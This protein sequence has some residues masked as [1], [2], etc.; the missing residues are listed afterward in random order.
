M[1]FA[2]PGAQ[3]MVPSTGKPKHCLR[4]A[5]QTIRIMKLTALLLTIFFLH[6]KA[7]GLSQTITYSGQNV[8]LQKVLTAIKDQTGYIFFYTE[9]IWTIS[10]PVSINVTNSKLKD[11]LDLVFRNQPLS[12]FIEEKTIIISRKLIAEDSKALT[13]TNAK[14]LGDLKG[15]VMTREGEPLVSANVVNK[16]TG[17]GTTTDGNGYF[18]LRGVEI[19]DVIIV[20][21]T[22]FTPRSVKVSELTALSFI[23]EVASS[24]LDQVV[25]QA[26]GTTTKRLATGNIAKVTAEEI[27][28]QPVLNPLQTLQGRVPG[29]IIT[30]TSGF[31]SAP[32][33]VEIRGRNNINDRITADPLYIIDGVPLTVM[34]LGGNSSYA[35]GSSGFI[36]NGKGNSSPARGQSPFFSLNPAD[37]ESIEI[38]KDAD[39]TAIYG[40]RGANGVILV[41]TK[42]G[43]SGKPKFSASISHGI[44]EVTRRWDMLNTQQ[45]RELRREALKNDGITPTNSN[46]Y[47]ILL[48]DSTR[49]TDWQEYAWGQVGR[50]T[51]AQLSL[52]GGNDQLTFRLGMG[53]NRNTQITTVSGA[54]QR[55]SVS[56]GFSFRTRDGKFN[57]SMNNTYSFAKSDMV[58]LPSSNAVLLPPNAPTVMDSL[59]NLNYAGWKPKIYPF[60]SLF[61]PYSANTNFLNS[62][63]SLGYRIV[64]GLSFNTSLGYNSTVAKN[65][66]FIPIF[67]QDPTRS[68][69]GTSNFGNNDIKNW[70]IEPQLEYN[71]FIAKGRLN[72]IVGSSI[73]SNSTTG[74]AVEGSGYTSDLLLRT[75]SNAPVKNAEELFGEYKY[76]AAFGRITYNWANK[77]IV[78][79]S[80]RRDGS[81]RFGESKRFGNFA[82]VGA[83]WVFSEEPIIKR[84]LGFLSFGKLRGSYG[85]TGSDAVGDYQYL[86]RW[87][88]SGTYPYAGVVPIVPLQHA[89]ENYHWPVN[90]KL[91]AAIDLGFLN[92]RINLSVAWYRNRCNDQ[93][94]SFPLAGMTGFT[95][96]TANSPALVQNM[97]LELSGSFRP[98]S[99]KDFKWNVHFNI[100]FNRNKLIAYPDIEKSPYATT[101]VVGQSLNIVKLLHYT[102]VDPQTGLYTFEDKFKDGSINVTGDFMDDRYVVENF[103]KFSGGFGTD[104]TYKGVNLS[105]FFN[106][107]KQRGYN[108]LFTN[109]ALPGTINNTSKYVFDRRWQKPGDQTEFAKATSRSSVTYSNFVTSDGAFTDASFIRLANVALSYVVPEKF[110]KKIRIPSIQLRLAA[111]NLF[112]ITRYKG[113]D[114]ETQNFGGMPPVK[115]VT[116]GLTLNF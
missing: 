22:G 91:E 58:S 79:I 26:Y 70:I 115:I 16:R 28:K 10:K 74:M 100:A 102:G 7:D 18:E 87:N 5:R 65:T 60:A 57:I 71:S 109:A 63:V 92:D 75:I 68:P 49:N 24:E 19:G 30:Q 9:N 110:T 111:Q 95:A 81:S 78:N 67:A 52:S 40:S 99:S 47:D 41:T 88:S 82:A 80:G 3:S 32:F 35:F 84:N 103:P 43:K 98:V 29:V 4:L 72:V 39:A 62:N 55:G 23:M 44:S 45:Y 77:Y 14:F 33:K 106:F 69:T 112:A 114:P 15:K 1:N 76:F 90:K 37:I 93:L 56:M 105:L 13:E 86:T 94:I 42:K 104:F 25:M 17:K 11:V 27:S 107:R 51:D 34:E 12:Y 59:G 48:W 2:L 50:V 21:Y 8:S 6:V 53:Y 83:A 97:G 108:A 54:D 38:L 20:T 66:S 61:S 101:L 46:A 64:K 113:I 36:Q 89:N 31:A 116:G 85:T 73:Q 96:V